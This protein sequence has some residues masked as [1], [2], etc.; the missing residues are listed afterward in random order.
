MAA[1][2]NLCSLVLP[3]A[4]A[5]DVDRMTIYGYNT[6]TYDHIWVRSLVLPGARAFDV[7]VPAKSGVGG[8][9]FMV[10]AF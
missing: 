4:R 1:R 5:F 2:Y 8:C 9:V 3:G 6:C 7:G 10:S